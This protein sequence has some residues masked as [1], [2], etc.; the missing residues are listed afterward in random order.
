MFTL[1]ERF[2]IHL[3]YKVLTINTLQK[4]VVS[5]VSWPVRTLMM[6]NLFEV[7]SLSK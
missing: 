7:Y 2:Y 3:K 1:F 4:F 5:W 6:K